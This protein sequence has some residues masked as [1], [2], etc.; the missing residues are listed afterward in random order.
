[1][2]ENQTSVASYS[3][4]SSKE[5]F[6]SYDTPNIAKMKAQYVMDKGLAGS[7][8]WDL[9]TDK[10]GDESLVYV[11]SQAY[12]SLDQ[13]QNHIECASSHPNASP[14]LTNRIARSYSD[15]EWTNIANNM[16][17]SSSSSTSATATAT[18]SSS[19]ST[20]ATATT[21]SATATGSNTAGGQCAGVSA[22]SSGTAY[23]GGETVTYNGDLWSAK[24][25]T[26]GDTPGGSG[27]CIDRTRVNTT[28]T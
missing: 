3:Y 20:T 13:T 1:M 19:G 9:S 21:S 12:G 24:W 26:Q 8:F 5:E 2:T 25:W 18:T 17:E 10:T 28:L 7:M 22:W 16:G 27:M 23:T 15:S 4:D 11:T 6:V 14:Q